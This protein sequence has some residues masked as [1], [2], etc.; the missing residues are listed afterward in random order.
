MS[1]EL[2]KGRGYDWLRSL[3]NFES[4]RD[5]TP[6]LEAIT[7]VLYSIG[8]PQT[9]FKAIHI[10]GTNGKTTVA[11]TASHVL[12]VAGVSVG[13]FT[14][15]DLGSITER[16][17]INGVQVDAERLNEELLLLSEIAQAFGIL[18]L[19]YFE[20]LT[21][22]AFS[23]FALEG[24]EVAV[25]EVGMG[26]TWDATNVLDAEVAVITS[27]GLD[28]LEQLGPTEVD[29]ARAKSGIVK[30]KST[31]VMGK[32]SNELAEVILQ[33]DHKGSL[34]L[35][36]EIEVS[37]LRQ[38]VGGWMFDL[39]TPYARYDEL[40]VSLRGKHQLDNAALAIAAVEELKMG[41]I[42]KE[43]LETSFATLKLPGRFEVVA[44]D[45]K[46]LVVLDVAHNDSSAREL[47]RALAEELPLLKGHVVLVSLTH[48]R[49][50]YEFIRALGTN[51]IDLLVS[52]DLQD[53]VQVDPVLVAE[54]ASRLGVKS[55]LLSNIDEGLF[56]YLERLRDD[57]VLVVTGSHRLV[58][59]VKDLLKG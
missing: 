34:R 35:G 37:N 18:D 29:I 31:L 59:K 53:C 50:P 24:V 19:S 48:K 26:G 1:R 54:A 23:L 5:R 14:S 17:R 10:T 22:A 38:G 20:A 21:A 13:L 30:G 27:I 46:K 47:R 6:N 36:S 7:R 56:E 15:P 25:V 51:D 9:A 16:I 11:S 57:Q 3:H 4:N 33:R 52:V 8:D 2:L 55:E 28:H 42:S 44:M 12:T 58:G 41:P 45:A 49:D 32:I 43:I 39:R 40:F